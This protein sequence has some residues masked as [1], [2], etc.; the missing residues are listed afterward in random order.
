MNH[1]NLDSLTSMKLRSAVFLIAG[2]LVAATNANA[3]T[4]TIF[5]KA[6]KILKPIVPEQCREWTSPAPVTKTD[7]VFPKDASGI[8]GE[9]A[10]LLKIGAAGEYLGVADFLATDDAYA[11]A[12]EDAVKNWTFK[13]AVCNGEAMISEA[14]V[15][16]KF[17]R[18]GGITYPTGATAVKR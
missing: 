14:R 13:P 12:A 18:E 17:R 3:N 4:E 8:T 9:A 7:V 5:P 16:F 11:R 2:A 6:A 10:L 15:D 1:T